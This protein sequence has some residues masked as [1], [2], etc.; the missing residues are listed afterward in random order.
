M[1]LLR[2][3]HCQAPALSAKSAGLPMTSPR[4]LPSRLAGTRSFVASA[5]I[6]AWPSSA[7]CASSARAI[8]PVPLARPGVPKSRNSWALKW[9]RVTTVGM[10]QLCTIASLPSFQTS[11]R[12]L[13][14]GCSPN[15]V[16][17]PLA[18]VSG[19]AP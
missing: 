8:Q 5:G 6:A 12:P 14:D 2:V 19:S 7:A 11:R 15:G 4:V 3:C 16:A 13:A 17:A 1:P 9:L 10:P 18:R